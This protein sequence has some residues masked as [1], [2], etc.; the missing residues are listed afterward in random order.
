M[1][2]T[3]AGL[4]GEPVPVGLRHRRATGAT[5]GAPDGRCAC[6]L[7]LA[8]GERVRPT[9]LCPAAVHALSELVAGRARLSMYYDGSDYVI[10]TSDAD[11]S[12]L[13]AA[14]VGEPHDDEGNPWTETKPDTVITIYVES[15]TTG[16]RQAHSLTAA[17]WIE[18]RGRCWLCSQNV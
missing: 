11:A 15:P 12:A 1:S 3:W 17:E 10:A 6:G 16:R 4:A 7:P 2:R 8:P 14:A 18:A 5:R 13:W 9:D